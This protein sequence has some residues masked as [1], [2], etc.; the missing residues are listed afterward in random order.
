[1]DFFSLTSLHPSSSFILHYSRSKIWIPATISILWVSISILSKTITSFARKF[2]FTHVTILSYPFRLNFELIIFWPTKNKVK[3]ITGK[4]MQKTW[5]AK[6]LKTRKTS[7]TS[8]SKFQVFSHTLNY[9][10]GLNINFL[11]SKPNRKK[12]SLRQKS[13]KNSEKVNFSAKST[14]YY[15]FLTLAWKSSYSPCF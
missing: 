9:F 5:N 12:P 14:F 6:V 4:V 2:S 8:N 3:S 13:P 11:Q 1:M 15:R 7:K 10:H